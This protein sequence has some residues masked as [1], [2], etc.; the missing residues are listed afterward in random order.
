MVWTCGNLEAGLGAYA[1]MTMGK[2]A[3]GW[4]TLKLVADPEGRLDETDETDNAFEKSFYVAHPGGTEGTTDGQGPKFEIRDG[5]LVSVALNGATAVTIPKEVH[6]IGNAAFRFCDTLMSV[7]IPDTV[8]NIEE[9]AFAGCAALREALIPS[10]VVRIGRNA[11]HH[12]IAL[13]SA[14]L[15]EGLTAIAPQ[16]FRDCQ[17]L[18]S[19]VV[20]HGVEEIGAGAF[21]NCISLETISLPDSLRTIAEGAFFDCSAIKSVV[22]PKNVSNIGYAAFCGCLGLRSIAILGALEDY[23]IDIFDGSQRWVTSILTDFTVQATSLWTGP[24]D[25]WLGRKVEISG[26]DTP[27]PPVVGGEEGEGAVE[28]VTTDPDMSGHEVIEPDDITEA[29]AAPKVVTLAGAAYDG[30]DV[31]GIVEL[32]LGKVSKGKSKVSGSV[33]T[34][35]GKKHAAKAVNLT[36]IDG[37]S[38]KAVSLDVKDLGKMEITIGG[39]QFAGSLG[40]YHVQTA[41]VGGNWS[42]GSAKVYVDAA[43][44]SLPA[45]TLEDLLPVGEPVVAAGG[46]WKFAKAAV[47]KWSKPK[48]GTALPEIYDEA[49]GKGLV[50][51]TS[52]DKT[53]LS[54]LKLTYTPKKGTFKG[55]F[56]VYALEGAGKSTKLKK[57]TVKVS[58]VVVD[59]VGC[60]T[61]TCKNPAASW[62]VTVR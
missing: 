31:V 19:I 60:G 62:P 33:T 49:S 54:G 45:G 13:K 58:G 7:E 28:P 26:S 1:G 17:S 24:A 20:P 21:E 59:G 46:K 3:E 56:K 9:R 52:G 27:S 6:S 38:P 15:P 8:T 5:I 4:H 57:C 55:S 41:D 36:E 23:G 47:V 29:F 50:V 14:S 37:L 34:L 40:G 18:G 48:K 43:S 53:N 2:L 39:T 61:A 22:I 16:L 11:F 32:K 42:K 51:D 44:A 35:D 10:N 25:V 12:C 30:N